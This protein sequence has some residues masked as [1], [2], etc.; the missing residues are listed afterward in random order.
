K[1]TNLHWI[2]SEFITDDLKHFVDYLEIDPLSGGETAK[3]VYLQIS[4]L[5]DRPLYHLISPRYRIPGRRG[6]RIPQSL[7][8]LDTSLCEHWKDTVVRPRPQNYC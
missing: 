6:Y 7:T 2:D 4:S 8:R 3:A 1:S 5:P